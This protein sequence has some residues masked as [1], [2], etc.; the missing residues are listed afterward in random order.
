MI[1]T[2]T[3]RLNPEILRRY[4]KILVLSQ[5]RIVETGSYDELIEANGY[6]RNM[7]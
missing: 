2:V 7:V 4:D 3:H 1:V 6:L 5:G